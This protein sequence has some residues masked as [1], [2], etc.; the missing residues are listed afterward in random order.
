[1]NRV[2]SVKRFGSGDGIEFP[3]RSWSSSISE[4]AIST[5]KP[6]IDSD[7]LEALRSF[8]TSGTRF[9]IVGGRAV[10]F[11]GH[12]RPAKDLDLLVDFSADNRER[13]S[14]ALKALNAGI[15]PFETLSAG[16]RYQAKLTFYPTVEFLTAIEGVSFEEAWSDGIETVVEGVQV[17]IISKLHLMASKQRSTRQLDAE[18]IKALEAIP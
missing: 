9:I 16:R 18:D 1:M 12:P 7:E 10:Q 15:P 2:N 3:T 14:R 4:H 13:L 17:R 6:W 8:V 11:H 5:A